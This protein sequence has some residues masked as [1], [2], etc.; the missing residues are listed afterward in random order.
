MQVQDLTRVCSVSHAHGFGNIASP[1]EFAKTAEQTTRDHDKC[2]LFVV[3]PK[4]TIAR[5]GLNLLRRKKMAKRLAILDT[6]HG[7]ETTL[8]LAF[9]TFRGRKPILA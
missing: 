9:S 7:G 8:W 3:G 1:E 6:G 2:L 4:Q 5:E